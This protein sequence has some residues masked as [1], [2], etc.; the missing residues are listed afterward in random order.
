MK[1]NNIPVGVNV[2][3]VIPGLNDEE[4]PRILKEAAD[5]GASSAGFIMLRLPFSVKDLFVEW[6][7]R[8]FPDRA[9]KVLNKI[10][11]MR[12]GKLNSYEW[13]KRFT[14]EGE[15][16]DTIKNLFNLSCRKYGL[17][18]KD[19]K[20]DISQFSSKINNQMELF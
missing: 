4:I 9:N 18:K 7:M 8:E 14:G 13:G 5:C 20:T 15:L 2:A 3:P 11:E 12:G 6:L 16:A 17:N 19:F 1:E 10:K